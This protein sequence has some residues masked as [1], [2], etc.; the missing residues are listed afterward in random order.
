MGIQNGHASRESL[1]TDVGIRSIDFKNDFWCL[2]NRLQIFEIFMAI[3]GEA[4][5]PIIH[6][7]V[8]N[9]EAGS[10]HQDLLAKDKHR[11]E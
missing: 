7:D 5:V 8:G 2:G 9:L 11:I 4:Q 1:F 10:I 6:P 3:V